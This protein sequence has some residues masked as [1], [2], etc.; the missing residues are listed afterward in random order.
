MN[1]LFSPDNIEFILY[2]M[3][4]LITIISTGLA[5]QW[6]YYRHNTESLKNVHKAEVANLAAKHNKECAEL[7]QK[8]IDA[9]QKLKESLE[10]EYGIKKAELLKKTDIPLVQEVKMVYVKYLHIRKESEEPVYSKYLNRLEESID[11][12]SEYHYY[13]FNKYSTNNNE[14]QLTDRSSG[15]VDQNILYPWKELTFTDIPSKKIKGMITQDVDSCDSYF[16]ATTYYNGFKENNEDIGMKMEMDTLEARMVADFSSIVGLEKLFTKEP[17]A[18]KI[19]LDGKKNKILGGF[20]KISDG[21]YHLVWNNLKKGES[22][23]MDFH[24]NWDYLNDE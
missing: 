21:V 8:V 20:E 24:V 22:L 14:I 10:K 9:T 19:D 16:S 13:R 7:Q 5:I 6:R 1:E 17:D 4:G 12:N 15:I 3:G 23:L 18:Y 2:F 11:V